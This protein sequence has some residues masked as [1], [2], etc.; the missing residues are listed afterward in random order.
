MVLT[1]YYIQK[2]KRGRERKKQNKWGCSVHMAKRELQHKR[3]QP[4]ITACGWTA[5]RGEKHQPFGAGAGRKP[6]GERENAADLGERL[7]GSGPAG[8]A[9][10]RW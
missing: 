4:E 7:S 1:A 6:C 8:A 2:I 3:H 5:C 9:H 10:R